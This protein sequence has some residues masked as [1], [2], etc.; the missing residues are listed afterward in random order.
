M[1]SLVVDL[2]KVLENMRTTYE[3]LGND[4]RRLEDVIGNHCTLTANKVPT[5]VLSNLAKEIKGV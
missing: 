1:S 3:N 2:E 4:I 5:K